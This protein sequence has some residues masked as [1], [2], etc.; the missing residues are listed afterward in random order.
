MLLYISF[1]LIKNYLNLNLDFA[2]IIRFKAW[3]FP[4]LALL[5]LSLII[6]MLLGLRFFKL[7]PV[8]VLKN[9]KVVGSKRYS[10]K[11]LLTSQFIIA[12]ILV[13]GTIGVMKQIHYMQKE[14]F[15]MEID[16]TLV[17]RIPATKELNQT[18]VSFR[19]ELRKVPGIN[20]ITFSTII[21]G[22]KNSWVKGGIY[23]SGK[24]SAFTLQI[25]QSNVASNFFKFFDV[26]LLAGRHFLPDETNWTTENRHVILNKEA[27][28][29]LSPDNLNALIGK[30]LYDP[31]N[32]SIIGEIVGIIDGYFQ[33]SLD[34]EIR[35]TIF[36]CDQLGRFLFIKMNPSQ[37]K[38]TLEEIK[39]KFQEYYA[40]QYWDY[41]FLDDFFNN[42]YQ[43]HI[44]FNRSVILFSM[45]AMIISALSLLGLSIMIS[46][47]RTKEIGIRKVNGS[48]IIEIMTMLNRDFIKW[49][50]IAFLIACPIAWYAMHKWL[51]NF[52]YKTTLSWWV[53]AAAGGIAMIIAIVTVSWQSWRAATRN[54]VESLRYE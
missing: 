23:L 49:V 53:F 6:G 29:A 17:L 27:A 47:R 33:N 35:P 24:E 45:M 30:S 2:S 1:P 7:S 43:L 51:E 28:T 8:N 42:Q 12:I 31:D 5:L 11:L 54:P 39:S 18:Q 44:Q 4:A 3:L 48:S 32:K 46:W 26:T 16:Q 9:N 13:A 52:A 20:D 14:A 21:P 38:E 37:I 10:Y 50:A 40:G 19:E 41:F 15:S 22:E 36:N 34:Q 25:Y